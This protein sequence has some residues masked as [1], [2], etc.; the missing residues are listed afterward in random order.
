MGKELFDRHQ[1]ALISPAFGWARYSTSLGTAA[2]E[3]VS[4]LK[5]SCFSEPDEA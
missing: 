1:G 5:I 3:A 2:T 4:K